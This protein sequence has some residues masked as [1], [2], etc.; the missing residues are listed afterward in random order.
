MGWLPEET[1]EPVGLAK[2]DVL[3]A[4]PNPIVSIWIESIYSCLDSLGPRDNF[5]L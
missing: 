4:G 2:E 1:N 3:V 5:D